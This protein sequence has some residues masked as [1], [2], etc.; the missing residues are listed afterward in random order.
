MESGHT[1]KLDLS[2]VVAN[3]LLCNK[4]WQ[5]A[6]FTSMYLP[7]HDG[8]TSSAATRGDALATRWI[9]SRLHR[10]AADCD[11]VLSSPP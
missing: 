7:S 3:R 10:A 6:K 5:A 8:V 4:A 1:V 11:H 2:K 9:L